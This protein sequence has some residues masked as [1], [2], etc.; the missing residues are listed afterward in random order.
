MLA[1]AQDSVKTN[2]DLTLASSKSAH[3]E[4]LWPS[5][6]RWHPGDDERVYARAYRFFASCPRQTA[7]FVPILRCLEQ[8]PV[9]LRHVVRELE[10]KPGLS[11]DEV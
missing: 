4:V 8:R 9:D 2:D 5:E 10:K 7:S 11:A 1:I 6:A 3:V